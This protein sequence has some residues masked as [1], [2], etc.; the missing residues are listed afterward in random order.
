M[1][2]EEEISENV[3]AVPV[4]LVE[5]G[6]LSIRAAYQKWL[7][8]YRQGS[9]ASE[10]LATAKVCCLFAGPNTFPRPSG[11]Q[12]GIQQLIT[13]LNEFSCIR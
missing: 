1:E 3:I 11:R 7:T 6:S 2:Y 10:F 5:H 9:L 12:A 8:D 13:E 4:D